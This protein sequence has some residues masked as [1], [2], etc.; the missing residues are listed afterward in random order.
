MRNQVYLLLY[1]YTQSQ[2]DVY[3]LQ[4]NQTKALINKYI[5]S[6]IVILDFFR[7][8]LFAIAC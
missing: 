6:T 4:N 5:K 1:G 8:I 2:N 3:F 7:Q